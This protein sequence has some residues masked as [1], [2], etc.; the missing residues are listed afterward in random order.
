MS[1][2]MIADR[3]A[4]QDVMLNYAAAVDERDIER[5]RACFS[6]DVEVVGFAENS[7][8][9]RDTWVEHVWGELQKYP[10]TQHL[11]APMLAE[12]NGDMARTRSDFQAL[13]GLQQEQQGKPERFILWAT[14][15]TT[16]HRING[17]W[18]IQRHELQVRGTSIQ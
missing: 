7:I 13:H 4:V 1:V 5:Y 15:N 17:E 9:G 16:M 14:Y 6:E 11:L 8:V 18:K 12:I 3:Q 2:K 10:Y